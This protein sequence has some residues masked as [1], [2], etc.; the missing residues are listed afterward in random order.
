MNKELMFDNN[1]KLA[2]LPA[3]L[4]VAVTGSRVKMAAGERL[5][6]I[7]QM[8]DSVGATVAFTLKQHTAASGGTSKD[9]SVDNL[10]FKKAG[11]ATVFTKVDPNGVSAAVYDLSA[12]FGSEEGIAVFQVLQDQLD[13]E[14]GF[15]YV[16][17]NIAAAGVAKIA[18]TSYLM[19]YCELCPAYAESI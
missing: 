3:D 2:A 18:A 4:A 10:Y 15:A 12:D 13:T 5:A 1:L 6:I 8:G 14:N 17:V 7:C 16:S 11:A 9:L 19:Q